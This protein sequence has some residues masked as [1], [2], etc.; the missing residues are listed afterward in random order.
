MHA[1]NLADLKSL[2][3]TI[4]ELVSREQS[5]CI[6][7]PLTESQANKNEKNLFL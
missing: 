1:T 7:I 4:S 2:I 3:D 5:K 6:W